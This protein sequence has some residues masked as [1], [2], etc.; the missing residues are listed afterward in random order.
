MKLAAAL[1]WASFLSDFWWKVYSASVYSLG[2]ALG[3]MALVACC[4]T[5]TWLAWGLE[6]EG[7][8]Q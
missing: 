5:L 6:A 2:E 1:G 7:P 3:A 4:V 8:N